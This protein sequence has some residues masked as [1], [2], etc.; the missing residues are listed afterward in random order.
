MSGPI[1]RKPT[2]PSSR[3]RRRSSFTA[4]PPAPAAIAMKKAGKYSCYK[5]GISTSGVWHY[6]MRSVIS[7]QGL[8]EADRL[9]LRRPTSPS[10]MAARPRTI[11]PTG[12]PLTLRPAN[13]V[14]PL[15]LPIQSSS[16]TRA[17]FRS[18]MVRSAS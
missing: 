6:F 2:S 4:L 8:E 14:Q 11:V 13:G 16:I 12:Q 1:S 9:A 17:A 5:L 3:R 10:H 15:L 7:R 18:T